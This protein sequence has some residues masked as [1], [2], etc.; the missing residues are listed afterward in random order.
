MSNAGKKYRRKLIQLFAL[1]DEEMSHHDVLEFTANWTQ[2]PTS[3][4][5]G[6]ILSK[7]SAFEETGTVLSGG[8]L[9]KAGNWRVNTYVLS[10][11]GLDEADNFANARWCEGC[12]TTILYGVHQGRTANNYCRSCY[13]LKMKEK[14]RGE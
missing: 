7:D 6:N 1:I 9:G 8:R 10:P 14:R 13:L 3:Q 5:L 12:K 4:Q 11:L 2:G